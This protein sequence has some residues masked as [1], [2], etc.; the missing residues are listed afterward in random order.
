MDSTVLQSISS[1]Y[2]YFMSWLSTLLSEGIL[3]YCCSF[4]LSEVY[5]FLGGQFPHKSSTQKAFLSWQSKWVVLTFYLYFGYIA[6]DL[7]RIDVYGFRGFCTYFFEKYPEYFVSPLRI[8]GSAVE[9]LF[10]QFKHNAGGKLDS[11]NYITARCAHLVK[12]SAAHHH[13]SSGYRNQ[14][15]SYMKLSLQKKKYATK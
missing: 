4:Q 15:L 7:L 14:T 9:S 6:W 10:S 11:C 3:L 5:V 8:S 13:S 12:Q 2:Q 1:G